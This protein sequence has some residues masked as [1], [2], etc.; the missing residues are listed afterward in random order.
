MAILLGS[1][2]FSFIVNSLLLVPLI[3][4]LYRL[5]FQRQKEKNHD[6]LG[7]LTPIFNKFHFGKAGIPV[8]GG[9]LSLI[10]TPLIFILVFVVMYVFWLPVTSVYPIGQETG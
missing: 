5:R 1:L 2:L 9:I 4:L 10:L 6:F 3:N 8:G 7:K